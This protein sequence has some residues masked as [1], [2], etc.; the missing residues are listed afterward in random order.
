[1]YHWLDDPNDEQFPLDYAI[2]EVRVTKN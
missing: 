2:T 1:M